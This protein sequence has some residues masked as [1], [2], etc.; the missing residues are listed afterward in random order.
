MKF[1]VLHLSDDIAAGT[2][3]VTPISDALARSQIPQYYL[4]TFENDYTLVTPCSSL[5]YA[6]VLSDPPLGYG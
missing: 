6:L 2:S 3:V 1:V 4:S 5:L